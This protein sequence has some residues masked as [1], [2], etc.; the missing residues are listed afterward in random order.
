MGAEAFNDA[1]ALTL[2]DAAAA[3]AGEAGFDA[4]RLHAAA[5]KRHTA[6][7]NLKLCFILKPLPKNKPAGRWVLVMLSGNRF[8]MSEN[9]K[10]NDF[11]GFPT[12]NREIFVG[13][14]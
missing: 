11:D 7:A 12:P 6:V 13:V 3:P 1:S 8:Y 2:P 9:C 14:A 5:D 10:T 4:W